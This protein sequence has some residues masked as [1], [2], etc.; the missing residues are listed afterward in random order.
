MK[1]YGPYQRALATTARI[2]AKATAAH[3][4]AVAGDWPAVYRAIGQLRRLGVQ[5]P[6]KR[7]DSPNL[8]AAVVDAC[9]DEATVAEWSSIF[10]RGGTIAGMRDVLI[11]SRAADWTPGNALAQFVSQYEDLWPRWSAELTKI[12]QEILLSDRDAI[13]YIESSAKRVLHGATMA[14]E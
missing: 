1:A 11:R 9:L 4:A 5:L 13:G 7:L 8:D 14:H 2:E 3:K 6:S 12:T 10:N